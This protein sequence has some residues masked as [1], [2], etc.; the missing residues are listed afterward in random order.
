MA[1]EGEWIKAF[2]VYQIHSA[3]ILHLSLYLM[4]TECYCG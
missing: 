3:A 4:V 1:S 2:S